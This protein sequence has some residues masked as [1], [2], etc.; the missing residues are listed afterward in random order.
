[1][2]SEWSSHRTTRVGLLR[3]RCLDMLV[4]PMITDWVGCIH[5]L[6]CVSGTR[7]TF[8]EFYNQQYAKIVCL[9][10]ANLI[11]KYQP[12]YWWI[13]VM[14][15]LRRG[16]VIVALCFSSGNLLYVLWTI[17][18]VLIVIWTFDD[19]TVI[20]YLQNTNLCFSNIL[21]VWWYH[22]SFQG[23]L[24]NTVFTR[25]DRRGDRS[26]KLTAPENV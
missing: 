18:M 23:H 22:W 26:R 1:M 8:A 14:S 16:L 4:V 2:A 6:C 5:W 11:A 3:D 15:M 9:S 7:W 17:T 19:T 24:C 10:G 12:K 21:V 20:N 13:F 25:G